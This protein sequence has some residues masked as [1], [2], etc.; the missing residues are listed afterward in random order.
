MANSPVNSNRLLASRRMKIDLNLRTQGQISDGKET[1]ADVAKIDAQ[2][3]HAA[4]SG[5]NLDI[6]VQ[7]LAFP[8]PP[9]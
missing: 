3:M 4:G 9:V 1:H 5:E 2:G 7:Q 8:A 6:G